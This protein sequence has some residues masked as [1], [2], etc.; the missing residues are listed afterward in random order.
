MLQARGSSMSWD[1]TRSGAAE[2]T[3]ALLVLQFLVCQ[4]DVFMRTWEGPSLRCAAPPGCS[5][6]RFQG[7]ST[8]PPGT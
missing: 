3:M 1:V 5:G 7:T 2:C 6:S 8:A 4:S